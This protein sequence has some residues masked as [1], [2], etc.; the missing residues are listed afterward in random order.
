MLPRFWGLFNS[1]PLRDGSIQ[2]S[3]IGTSCARATSWIKGLFA[4][5]PEKQSGVWGME[6]FLSKSQV[7]ELVRLSFSQIDRLE[8]RGAFPARVYINSRVRWASSQIAAWMQ[9]P[10]AGEVSGSIGDTT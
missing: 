7:R 8:K 9:N 10:N 6:R 1:E 2:E 4:V 3:R 5:T